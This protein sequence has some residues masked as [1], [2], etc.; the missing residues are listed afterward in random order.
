M[1]NKCFRI[2]NGALN[3]CFHKEV[4]SGGHCISQFPDQQ[5]TSIKIAVASKEGGSKK[6]LSNVI[7][8]LTKAF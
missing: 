1:Q 2:F 6:H 3:I 4:H 5:V 8:L 7:E